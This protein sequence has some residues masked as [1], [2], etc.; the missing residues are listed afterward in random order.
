MWNKNI[1]LSQI[2]RGWYL[3]VTPLILR[4][5]LF[6][7][8]LLGVYYATT[9][10]EQTPILKFSMTEMLGY[11]K[12][13]R[14]ERGENAT[15]ESKKHLFIEYHNY[16]VKTK[17][18]FRFLLMLL[19]NLVATLITNPIDVC[20]TKLITQQE[21]KY[22]GLIDCLRKVY[23]EEGAR[24][25]LGGI[26]PRFMFNAINGTMFLYIYEQVVTAFYDNQD[27]NRNSR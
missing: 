20:L 25:F 27:N 16:D 12:Y 26:H 2:G 18:N 6:R 11:L 10:V 3:G 4:D 22:N 13:C 23:R 17:M 24:K 9:N 14:E 8:S 7:S 5:F 15:F 19:G 21:R 1:P